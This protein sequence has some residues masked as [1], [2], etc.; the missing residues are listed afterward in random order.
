[1][2]K[3]KDDDKAEQIDASIEEVET[4]GRES[5]DIHTL[6]F[7]ERA[8]AY[9]KEAVP[10]CEKWGIGPDAALGTSSKTIEAVL[11]VKDLWQKPEAQV[12]PEA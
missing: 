12:E 8:E 10:V 4:V 1:M 11:V 2:A 7:Q 9:A 6:S 5:V 3:A